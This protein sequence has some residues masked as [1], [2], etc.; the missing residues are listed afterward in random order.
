MWC[1]WSGMTKWN[2][3]YHNFV[4]SIQQLTNAIVLLITVLNDAQQ[5]LTD[6]DAFGFPMNPDRVISFGFFDKRQQHI[7]KVIQ[8]T[9]S[10]G[11]SHVCD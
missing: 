6:M 8:G 3:Q 9:K 2:E 7:Q 4:R 11:K 10:R 1:K 5:K